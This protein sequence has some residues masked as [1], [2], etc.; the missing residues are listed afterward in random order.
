M[1]SSF[2]FYDLE[3]SGFSP[4]NARIVQ[5]AGQR[6]DMNLQPIGE[7]VNMLI[8][9]TPDVVPEPDAVLITGITPQ[10]TLADGVTEAEFL[11]V[12]YEEVVQP[13][14]IFTGF[15][16]VRFDDEFMRFINYRNF[17]DAYEWHWQNGASRWDILDVVRMTRA[18]RPDGIEWPFAPD[19]KPANRLEL[20]SSVNKLEHS[21]A[22]DALSDVHA[23][24]AV[25]DL[26]RSKQPD[27]FDYL[28]KMRDKKEVAALVSKG[29]PFVYTSGRYPSA[30]LHTTV[31]VELTKHPQDGSSLVYDLRHDPTPFLDMSVEELV[32]AWKFTRDPD[33]L[34]LPVK[35]IKFNRCPAVAPRGV[36]KDA[37]TEERIGLSLADAA[38]HHKILK[39]HQ[40]DFAAKVLK[41]V[42]QLD[43]K[44]EQTQG[45]LIDNQ[46]TVD[47]RLYEG[48]VGPRDK[49]LMSVVRAAKPDELS[50]LAGDFHDDRLKSMLPLYKA[51]NYPS[52]LSPE[53]QVEW[54]EFCRLRLFEGGDESRLAK[55]FAR[56]GELASGKISGEQQ[57]LL[58][59]LQLYGQS[60]MPVDAAG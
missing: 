40:S 34:R 27:L 31:T 20:L 36:I 47:E 35:T 60:I 7:P 43:A 28:L 13:N 23:T 50:D 54:D 53:E 45:A 10:Q 59:E 11:K 12:F 55:F 32:E 21:H 39:E 30:N 19:G 49:Q 56:L 57:Y 9:L 33:V 14:T 46:L 42:A 4:R 37:E 25:A 41:A 24:I 2:F 1:K 26:V 15:N 51:R 6:T 52:S 17:Y 44:R 18:L 58:E 5:F 29:D 3:T 22:H 8:K 48:F 38:K 16:S